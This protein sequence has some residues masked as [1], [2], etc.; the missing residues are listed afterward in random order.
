MF[1]DHPEARYLRHKS[2]SNYNQMALVLGNT[3]PEGIQT[4]QMN[5][6][7]V[8]GGVQ[9]L[10]GFQPEN[11]PE[12]SSSDG[13]EPKFETWNEAKRL[14]SFSMSPPSLNQQKA[15]DSSPATVGSKEVV[16]EAPAFTKLPEKEEN[17]NDG[18]VDCWFDELTVVPDLE[19]DLFQKR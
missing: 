4:S 14:R 11:V 10:C 8:A 2:I 7:E 18:S 19:E 1:Q 12:S 5:S 13:E 3:V 6:F 16:N 17:E 15:Q 9:I